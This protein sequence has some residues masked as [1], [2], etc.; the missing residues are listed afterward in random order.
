MKLTRSIEVLFSR[1]LPS[2]FSIA[3]LLTLVTM[4]LAYF[5]TE[6]PANESHALAILSY[7][8]TGIWNEALLVFAYQM[9]LILVLGHILVLSKPMGF[10]IEALTD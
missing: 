4:G 10:L 6:A 1:F 3:I 5:F 8:E 7:W 9:L 2:P